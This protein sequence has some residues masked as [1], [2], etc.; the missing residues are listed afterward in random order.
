MGRAE[1]RDLNLEGGTLYD[2]QVNY[3]RVRGK[4]FD[5]DDD[6]APVAKSTRT[7]DTP[8]QDGN[9]PAQDVPPPAIKPE[10]AR[11]GQ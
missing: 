5:F 2:P 7:V 3:E 1:A 4:F 9:I 10:G 8:V 6:P 11:S